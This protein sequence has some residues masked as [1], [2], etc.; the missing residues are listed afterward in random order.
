MYSAFNGG[1]RKKKE[2][3]MVRKKTKRKQEEIWKKK[4][5]N[6][7]KYITFLHYSISLLN[8]NFFL[9]NEKRGAWRNVLWLRAPLTED[10]ESVPSTHIGVN[11]HP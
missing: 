6:S 11:N 1:K 4:I 3:R 2:D 8:P 5:K 10:P 9:R 7:L